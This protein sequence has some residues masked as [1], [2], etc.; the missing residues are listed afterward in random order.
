[1]SFDEKN[2][3]REKF[4]QTFPKLEKMGNE[5][6]NTK[7]WILLILHERSHTQTEISGMRC[8]SLR[9]ECP[10]F[11]YLLNALSQLEKNYF[12]IKTT[13]DDDVTWRLK[14]TTSFEIRKFKDVVEMQANQK[15]QSLYNF[16]NRCADEPLLGSHHEKSQFRWKDVLPDML[17]ESAVGTIRT[18]FAL[19]SYV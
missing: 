1:M 8:K 5:L 14:D 11:S 13:I 17:K 10:E 15:G 18:M 4:F 7:L 9:I 6:F 16:I 12:V 19:L 3:H 2:H